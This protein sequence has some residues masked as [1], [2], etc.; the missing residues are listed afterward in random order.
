MLEYDRLCRK[1]DEI[2][3]KFV[4]GHVRAAESQEDEWGERKPFMHI[5]G[6]HPASPAPLGMPRGVEEI[7]RFV[8]HEFAADSLQYQVKF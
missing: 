4:Q 2:I 7:L 3:E 8:A 1:A 5:F 6:R